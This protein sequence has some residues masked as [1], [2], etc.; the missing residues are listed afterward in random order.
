[1]HHSMLALQSLYHL[2]YVTAHMSPVL[3]SLF[4]KWH[5]QFGKLASWTAHAHS[6]PLQ[7]EWSITLG[8]A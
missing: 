2:N 3:V 6:V 5:K 8:Q 4:I 7:T 1:M